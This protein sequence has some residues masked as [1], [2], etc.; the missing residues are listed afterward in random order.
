[1][2]TEKIPIR[3]PEGIPQKL[4]T[5]YVTRC[6]AALPTARE[7]LRR[8]DYAQIR[9]LGHRLR[10]SGGAYGILKVTEIGSAIEL[11]AGHDDATELESQLAAL[12]ECLS[13]LEIPSGQ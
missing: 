3:V 13:R 7:A 6:L 5:E 11:A 10:G 9:V 12:E 8:S 2:Q 4:V 1:M